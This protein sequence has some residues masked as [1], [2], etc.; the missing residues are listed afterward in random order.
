MSFPRHGRSSPRPEGP[1]R[2]SPSNSRGL[3]RENEMK[4]KKT[5]PLPRPFCC[6]LPFL[7]WRGTKV[8]A[9]KGREGD[10]DIHTLP[11][12]GPQKLPRNTR[13]A[14]PASLPHGT[15]VN[16]PGSSSAARPASRLQLHLCRQ[17]LLFFMPTGATGCPSARCRGLPEPSGAQGMLRGQRGARSPKCCLGKTCFYH[18][19]LWKATSDGGQAR[20]ESEEE[21]AETSAVAAQPRHSRQRVRD[22]ISTRRVTRRRSTGMKIAMSRREVA[23]VLK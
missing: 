20:G 12:P 7:P 5:Q 4:W 9:P 21:R 3:G 10:L 17:L 11:N 14:L 8:K 18:A 1:P 13:P 6:S 16:V 22:R 15:E 2:A 19:D 23:V